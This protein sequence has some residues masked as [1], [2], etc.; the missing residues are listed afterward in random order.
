MSSSRVVR[1][2]AARRPGVRGVVGAVAT[3]GLAVT[4]AWLGTAL[5]LATAEGVTP[6]PGG[7]GETYDTEFIE[8]GLYVATA[9]VSVG[10]VGLAA[11]WSWP[12]AA[13]GWAG[14]VTALWWGGSETVNRYVESG[15]SDGLEVFVYIVPVTA[16]IGGL[17]LLLALRQP[18]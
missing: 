3:A 2:S 10:L 17:I 11:R 1:R 9:V 7:P 15:W 5:A 13:V 8:G 16:G 14:A 6:V 12:T 18:G 4:V